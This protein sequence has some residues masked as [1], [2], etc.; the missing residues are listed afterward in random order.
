MQLLR[1]WPHNLPLTME[2]PDYKVLPLALP[3]RLFLLFAWPATWG[4]KM[5][6][7]MENGDKRRREKNSSKV[8]LA[9]GS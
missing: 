7:K 4:W 3:A 8:E 1:I 9:L 6:W 5:S 2:R